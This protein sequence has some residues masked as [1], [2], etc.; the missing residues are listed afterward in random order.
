MKRY[1]SQRQKGISC[2]K[3][4]HNVELKNLYLFTRAMKFGMISFHNLLKLKT[5]SKL[6]LDVISI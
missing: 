2:C 4:V 6:N 3:I 5:A 1:W